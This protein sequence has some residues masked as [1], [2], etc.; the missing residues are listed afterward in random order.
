MSA[1]LSGERFVR[2][3]KSLVSRA[4]VIV[5]L[6]LVAGTAHSWITPVTLRLEN[7]A[8]NSPVSAR[9]DVSGE[10]APGEAAPGEAAG[11]TLGAHITLAQ[12][13][14]LFDEGTIFVDA[15]EDH[16]RVEQGTIQNSVHLTSSMVA[17]GQ[18]ADAMAILDPSQ[19]VVIFCGGG[20]CDASE[21]LAILLR[22]AG[23]TR[24]HIFHDG[25]P[26][27][28]DAGF[29]VEPVGPAGGAP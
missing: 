24:L 15:R 28:R 1:C 2:S 12:A 6:G 5:G 27:W 4:G 11:A 20:T 14:S 18:G 13:K 21:N 22:Q 23:Y 9:A 26:A 16:E 3:T 7:P 29:P 25:F 8:L 19:P 17:S 10:A